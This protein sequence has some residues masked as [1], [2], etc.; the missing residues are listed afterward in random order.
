MALQELAQGHSNKAEILLARSPNYTLNEVLLVELMA[1]PGNDFDFYELARFVMQHPDWPNLNGVRLIAEQKIPRNMPSQQVLNWFTSYPPLTAVGFTRY[2]DVLN[3]TS[4]E[5]KAI[6]LVRSRWI[7]RN[8]DKDDFNA[9]YSRYKPLL[10]KEDHRKRL[11]RLLWDERTS[12]A[13]DM[14][15]FVNHKDELLAQARIA[16]IKDQSSVAPLINKV[17]KKYQNDAGLLYERMRWRLRRDMYQEALEIAMHPPKKIARPSLWWEKTHILARYLMEQ[18]KFTQAYELV[19]QHRLTD[20]ESFAY[21]QAEFLTG[22]LA[23][24]KINKPLEAE[25]RFRNIVKT[26]S[27]PISKARGYY[28]LGRAQEANNQLAEAGKS[29]EMAALYNTTFYGQLAID[30]LYENPY[31]LAQ[32][33]PPIPSSIRDDFYKRSIIRAIEQLARLD[34][35]GKAKEYF[36]AA[37]NYATKRVDFALLIELANIIERPD[38]AIATAKKAAQEG[39]LITGAAYPILSIAIPQPPDIAFTHALIRQESMFNPRA[40]SSVGAQ[41]LMQLMPDTAQ[42]VAREIGIRFDSSRLT[43]PHYNVRLGTY[44]IQKQIER[45]DGSLVLALAAYNAGPRRAQEW[46][47]TFGD[48]RKANVDTVDWI[49]TIS[50]YETRNYIQRILESLQ[51]YRARLSGGKAFLQIRNDLKR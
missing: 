19:K 2:I 36:L 48:P 1:Q 47:K 33:E 28:W 35:Y 14:F 43:D 27:A 51:F 32:P 41:G 31:I 42:D 16:L 30:K 25:A 12:A 22:W 40:G 34:L 11:N 6:K 29:Y 9:F 10:R 24:R 49:E 18:H 46:I 20:D 38:W 5:A 45:F 13:K 39:I 3:A 37:T 15:R 4:Q 26:A 50:I 17:P 7:D 21:L 8:F 44:F 23:L